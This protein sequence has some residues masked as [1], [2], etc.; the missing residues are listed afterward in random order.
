MILAAGRGERMRPLTDHTPKP[1]LTVRGKALIVWLI[2]A[3]ARAGIRDLVINHAH[4]GPA[5]EAGLGD[6]ARW[7]ISIRYSPEGSALETAGGIANALPLLGT[8][9]FMVVNG[10]IFCD[11]DFAR[12]SQRSLGADLAHLVLVANPPQH[13]GGDFS[14]HGDRVRD[15]GASGDMRTFAGI[16]LYDPRLFDG[17]VRGSRAPLAPLLRN[18]MAAD[19]VSGEFHAGAWHDVGTP[20]RLRQLDLGV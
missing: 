15:R 19:R 20:E 4:L 11:F 5:I 14:L 2:E 17:I 12:L 16:G 18:A 6:G 8:E 10:D 3:L 7:N 13:P 9:P 1:L